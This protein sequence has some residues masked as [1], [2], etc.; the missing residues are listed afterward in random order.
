MAWRN[1]RDKPKNLKSA[2]GTLP[3]FV[4][5]VINILAQT[6]EWWQTFRRGVAAGCP[7]GDASQGLSSRSLLRT[8][9]SGR[10]IAGQPEGYRVALVPSV[11]LGGAYGACKILLVPHHRS[12][13]FSSRY[14]VLGLRRR[15]NREPAND[16]AITWAT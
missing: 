14:A 6:A 16:V 10:W 4:K 13:C 5:P 8:A 15:E 12:V 3:S 9:A 1:D 11:I 7:T 2:Q